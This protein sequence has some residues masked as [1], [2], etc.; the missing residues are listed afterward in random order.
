MAK[1]YRGYILCRLSK[2]GSEWTIVDTLKDMNK[3]FSEDLKVTYAS[4]IYGAWDLI[5]EASFAQLEDLDKL[6]TLIRTNS[7]LQGSIEET[8]TFV[9]SKPDYPWA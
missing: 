6:V 2:I 5:I 4:P 1:L 9:S 8:T 7:T 3:D